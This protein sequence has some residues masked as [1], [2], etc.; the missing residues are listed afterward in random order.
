MKGNHRQGDVLLVRKDKVD[1]NEEGKATLALG[2]VTGHSHRFNKAKFK[3]GSNG[4]AQEVVLEQPRELIHE[5]HDNQMIEG[6]FEVRQQRRADLMG[7]IK[8]VMD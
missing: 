2:E 3:R 4:L 8:K 1:T 5:D 7:E 6:S